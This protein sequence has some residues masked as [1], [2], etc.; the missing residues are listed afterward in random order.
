MPPPPPYPVEALLEPYPLLVLDGVVDGFGDVTF[1]LV[2]VEVAAAA[3]V[4]AS[5][6]S[7]VSS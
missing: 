5:S 1:P 6:S 4:A 3:V 2:V 7:S